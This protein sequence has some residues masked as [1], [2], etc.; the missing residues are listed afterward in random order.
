MSRFFIKMITCSR[1]EAG[2]NA[3]NIECQID[4]LIFKLGPDFFHQRLHGIVPASFSSYNGVALQNNIHVLMIDTF[5]YIMDISACIVY[6]DLFNILAERRNLP[7]Q[8][9]NRTLLVRMLILVIQF[10]KSF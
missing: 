3:V 5:Y 9:P 8:L 2:I 1:A 10:G 7:F 6:N 4:G